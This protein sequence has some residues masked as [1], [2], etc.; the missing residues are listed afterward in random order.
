MSQ[1]GARLSRNI[2]A[3]A[4]VSAVIFDSAVP[5]AGPRG[6]TSKPWPNN[7]AAPNAT[8]QSR[9]SPADFHALGL[10]EWR[11][12]DVIEPAPHRLYRARVSACFILAPS[13]QRL[14]VKI[15]EA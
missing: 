10:S 1:A 15:G 13:D 2:A 12:A 11:T 4:T 9:S 3:R 6:S 7:S 5:E 14:P 8:G